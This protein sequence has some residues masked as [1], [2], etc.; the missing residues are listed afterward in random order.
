MKQCLTH[1]LLLQLVVERVLLVVNICTHEAVPDVAL[2]VA[3]LG[4]R[5]G[6]ACGQ[7]LRTIRCF[8]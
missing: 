5:E 8:T 4:C 2:L 1:S 6:V 3:S 7:Y